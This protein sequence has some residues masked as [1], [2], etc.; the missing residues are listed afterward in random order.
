MTPTEFDEH[1]KGFRHADK[2]SKHEKLSYT[3]SK[4]LKNIPKEFDWTTKGAVTPVIFLNF[5]NF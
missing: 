5:L 4:K 3:R 1:F 2:K